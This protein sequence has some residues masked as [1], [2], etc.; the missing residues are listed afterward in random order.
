MTVS[1][2]SDYVKFLT[3][4]QEIQDLKAIA[5]VVGVHGS[6]ALDLVYSALSGSLLSLVT[7][8]LRVSQLWLLSL[9]LSSVQLT[10]AS[11]LQLHLL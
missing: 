10:W 4:K 8:D 1:A 11:R 6:S 9:V 3:E 7:G 5:N 2:N